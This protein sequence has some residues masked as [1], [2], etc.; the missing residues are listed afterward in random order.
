MGQLIPAPTPELIHP[1]L[2]FLKG[3]DLEGA[4]PGIL[5]TITMQLVVRKDLE[6]ERHRPL[7]H[8]ALEHPGSLDRAGKHREQDTKERRHNRDH[9]QHLHQRERTRR[10]DRYLWLQNPIH[11]LILADSDSPWMKYSNFKQ[12]RLV[13]CKN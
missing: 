3:L 2:A 4:P 1:V 12:P 10:S 6:I 9:N 13:I 5:T 11:S 8:L 7:R